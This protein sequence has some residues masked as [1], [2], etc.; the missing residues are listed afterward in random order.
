TQ[1]EVVKQL[2][3]SSELF[4]RVRPVCGRVLAGTHITLLAADDGD[5][6]TPAEKE[7]GGKAEHLR[8]VLE[9]PL[10]RNVI[11]TDRS[12][13]RSEIGNADRRYDN[14]TQTRTL[15][16]QRLGAGAVERAQAFLLSWRSGW[17][18]LHRGLPAGLRL[19]IDR[20]GDQRQ[21]GGDGESG[22]NG[23]SVFAH[24]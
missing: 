22:K 6:G 5:A 1:T 16:R 24:H 3:K 18:L 9:Q 13:R 4:K 21:S 10:E 11:A 15:H 17:R 14:R 23:Y 12:G 20:N 7:V 19:R 8:V 2:Q